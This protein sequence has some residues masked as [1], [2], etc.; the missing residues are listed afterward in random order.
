MYKEDPN[1]IREDR[2]MK[3]VV[4]LSRTIERNVLVLPIG[5]RN[6]NVGGNNENMPKKNYYEGIKLLGAYILQVADIS[7]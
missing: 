7:S 4:I 6:I 1:L 2:D 3:T 5:D